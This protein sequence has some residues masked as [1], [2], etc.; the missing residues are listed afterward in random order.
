[1][2]DK[3]ETKNEQP[4]PQPQQPERVRDYDKYWNVTGYYLDSEGYD[5]RDR[6]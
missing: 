5:I 1:M 6:D 4:Q 3:K 2:K